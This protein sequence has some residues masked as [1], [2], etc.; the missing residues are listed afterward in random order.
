MEG[1]IVKMLAAS[2]LLGK[3]VAAIAA[4]LRALTTLM[5]GLRLSTAP[6]LSRWPISVTVAF[7]VITPVA[8]LA[9]LMK[10]IKRR[11]SMLYRCGK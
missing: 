6:V 1:S 10:S 7:R 3:S 4:R 2:P 8:Q 9:V 5:P 11:H